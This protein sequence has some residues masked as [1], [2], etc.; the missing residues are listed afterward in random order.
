[1]PGEG[2]AISEYYG[3]RTVTGFVM[4]RSGPWKYVYHSLSRGVELYNMNTDALEL[5][6][7]AKEA[8]NETI[9]SSLHSAMCRGLAE[10]PDRTERR[11]RAEFVDM[12]VNPGVVP[13]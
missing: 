12:R 10:H 2:S 6:N 13:L 3:F 11:C 1:M 5:R 8:G 9:S 4:F 7:L